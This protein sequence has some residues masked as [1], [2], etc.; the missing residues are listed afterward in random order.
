MNTSDTLK[1]L[2]AGTFDDIL[3]EIYGAEAVDDHQ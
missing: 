2:S 1:N 3:S